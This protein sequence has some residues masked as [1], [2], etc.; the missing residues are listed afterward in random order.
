MLRGAAG[1]LR[2]AAGTPRRAAWRI[3]VHYRPG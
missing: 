1:V 2:G 3:D